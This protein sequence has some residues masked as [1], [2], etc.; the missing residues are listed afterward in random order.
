MARRTLLSLDDALLDRVVAQLVETEGLKTAIA[1]TCLINKHFAALLKRPLAAWATLDL[2]WEKDGRLSRQGMSVLAYWL[3]VV[4][5]GV[6]RLRLITPWPSLEIAPFLLRAKALQELEVPGTRLLPPHLAILGLLTSLKSLH[7]ECDLPGGLQPLSSLASLRQLRRLGLTVVN[8]PL[9]GLLPPSL[10]ALTGL[11]LQL[12]ARSSPSHHADYHPHLR[13]PWA[14]CQAAS[15]VTTAV[16]E[17]VDLPLLEDYTAGTAAILPAMRHLQLLSPMAP[18]ADTALGHCLALESLKIDG[19]AFASADWEV[20]SPLTRLRSL[21]LLQCERVE[22][23]EEEEEEEEPMRSESLSSLTC[24]TS[25]EICGGPIPDAFTFLPVLRSLVLNEVV[26][27]DMDPGAWCL[28]RGPWL[29]KLESLRVYGGEVGEIREALRQATRLSSL[30]LEGCVWLCFS[31]EEL[32]LLLR[33]PLRHLLLDKRSGVAGSDR[34][35]KLWNKESLWVANELN[36]E[37]EMRGP[38]GWFTICTDDR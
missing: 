33:L 18:L 29:H 5:P 32:P 10:S 38:G 22:E 20:L 21:T 36:K 19:G 24:L 30:E 17:S 34:P 3:E 28:W 16:L 14:W 12:M 35:R 37:L 23:E 25:L 1:N 11:E 26:D 6:R 4:A 9:E 13:L 2:V 8:G 15:Q 31:R 7:C 27:D